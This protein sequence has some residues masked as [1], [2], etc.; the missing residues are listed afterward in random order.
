MTKV[1]RSPFVW[2]LLALA[3]PVPIQAQDK[4]AVA[5]RVVRVTEPR[6]PCYKLGLRFGRD[7]ILKWFLASGRTGLYVA[8]EHEGQVEAGETFTLLSRDTHGVT[9]A[10]ITRV[11]AHEK[12]DVA[13][14]QR[15]VQLPDLSAPWRAYFQ[16]QLH[17]RG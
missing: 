12:D 15:L 3:L 8:V 14:M 13:T 11:Y 10:D 6:L 5:H 16:A 1:F 17:K 9:V 7:D 2:I 4:S